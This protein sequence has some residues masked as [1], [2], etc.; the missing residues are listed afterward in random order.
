MKPVMIHADGTDCGHAG[1]PQSTVND[2]AGPR[3][4]AG[5]PVDRIR[6]HGQVLTIEEALHTFQSVADSFITALT[7]VITELAVWAQTMVD[8][9]LPT[10]RALAA[11]AGVVEEERAKDA[12]QT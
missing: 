6:F 11:A 4:A 12:A 8:A 9:L 7:P 5:Q 2:P 10:G 1:P 3:C